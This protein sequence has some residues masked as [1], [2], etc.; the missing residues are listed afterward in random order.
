MT[1]SLVG[2][3]YFCVIVIANTVGAVSG[4]GGGVL[5]KPIFDLIGAH[6]VAAIS[7]Y[8]TVAVFTMSIVSTSRQFTSG[9]KFN[10]RIVTWVSAGAVLGGI[11]GN[12]TFE[13]LLKLFKSDDIVQLIQ[14][15]LTILTLLFAFFYTRY[16]RPKFHL[17]S[18]YWYF[19][20]GLLLGFLASL[21]GI[22]G[23]PINVSLLMLLFALPIKEATMYSICTIFFSQLA[24]LITIGFST[25]FASYDLT[26]LFYII[27]AAIIG[28]LLGTKFS[29]ILSVQKVTMVFQIVILL[30]LLINLY[31][32]YRILMG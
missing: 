6:S 18:T 28:G 15:V 5:I 1:S 25:G 30:V 29:N 14:I 24:K 11:L 4:M 20:C 3:L 12:L 16:D 27:P 31:N 17:L 9:R 2:I 21:L 32:G 13:G 7:F 23:G 10:W 19:F 22:G 26:V 8:S